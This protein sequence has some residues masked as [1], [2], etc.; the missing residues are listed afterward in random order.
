VETWLIV[1]IVAIALAVGLLV[2][3][4]VAKTRWGI[5]FTGATCPSCGLAMPR[6]RPPAD[7]KEAAWGGWTCEKCGTKADKWGRARS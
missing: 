4:T 2:Y 7:A 1:L 6:T 5:N 3:G